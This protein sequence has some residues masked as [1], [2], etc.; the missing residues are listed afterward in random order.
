MSY[1]PYSRLVRKYA[2]QAWQSRSSFPPVYHYGTPSV[3]VSIPVAPLKAV[4]SKEWTGYEIARSA[5]V[6]V[7]CRYVFLGNFT[8][9]D[10]W[11]VV[12]QED[13]LPSSA[14]LLFTYRNDKTDAFEFTFH[15]PAIPERKSGDPIPTWEQ[16][17]KQIREADPLLDLALSLEALELNP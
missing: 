11:D 15:H 10:P 12:Q 4:I 13:K 14:V 1:Q 6:S 2:A 17:L 7:P 16:A 3:A 9:S 5:Y 8:L